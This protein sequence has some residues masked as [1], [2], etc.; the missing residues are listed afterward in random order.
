MRF[1]PRAHEFALKDLILPAVFIPDTARLI[2]V[3][4]QMQ[5]GHVHLAIV[6]DEHSG[7]EG[8][9]TLE[10]LLEEIVGEILDEHD[11]ALIDYLSE[12]EQ[13][14]FTIDGGLSVRE[15]NRKYDLDL[16]ESDD[17]TTVAGFLIVRAGRLL[18]VNDTVEHNGT[19][20]T[21][22]RVARRRIT[23]VK[24]ERNLPPAEADTTAAA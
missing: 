6:V 24:V 21:V 9:L 2:D 17:Y 7:V 3:L 22:E 15:V 18:N 11:E 5:A 23:H 19:R 8:I 10:D 1:L 20:F 14:V 16:P 13:S 12:A 4:R